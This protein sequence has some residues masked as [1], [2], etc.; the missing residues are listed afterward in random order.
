MLGSLHKSSSFS[1]ST[2]PTQSLEVEEASGEE[3]YS[4]YE[5]LEADAAFH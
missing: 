3:E 4:I 2:Y 1:L 5:A